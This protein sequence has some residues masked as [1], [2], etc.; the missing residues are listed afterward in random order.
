MMPD[1][2]AVPLLTFDVE[3]RGDDLAIVRC[4]GRLVA[5]L[6]VLFSRVNDLMPETQEIILD[7]SGL[8]YTDSMGLGTLVDCMFRPG[9]AQA[10]RLVLLNL[11]Q[12]IRH[13]LG[14]TNMLSGVPSS[15]RAG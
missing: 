1:G 6:R 3:Q 14:V 4:R 7:L 8:Q 10:A 9:I 2:T 12:Q 13:L 11:S 15:G 5:G